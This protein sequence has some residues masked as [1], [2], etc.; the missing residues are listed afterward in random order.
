MNSQVSRVVPISY[1]KP[2]VSKTGSGL[3]K[4]ILNQKRRFSAGEEERDSGSVQFSTLMK[5]FEAAGLPHTIALVGLFGLEV[6]ASAVGNYWLAW[7]ADDRFGMGARWYLIRYGG[8]SAVQVGITLTRQILRSV[9]KTPGSPQK[10]MI[11]QDRPGTNIWKA[12]RNDVFL[13][14]SS[15]RASRILHDA[16]LQA[17]CRTRLSFFH[18]NP[19]GRIM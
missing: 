8:L 4:K 13:Q 9:R 17:L 1:E 7:W 11:R 12:Q 14:V 5:Y 18:A 2:S 15:V 10:T 3:H 16:M 19:K 6:I